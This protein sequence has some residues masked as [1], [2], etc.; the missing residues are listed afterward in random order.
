[1]KTNGSLIGRLIVG[2]ALACSLTS[3]TTQS[4]AIEGMQVSIQSSNV[5]LSWPSDPSETYVVQYRPS[6]LSTNGWQTLTNSLAAATDT[7][8]TYF[9]HS[10]SVNFGSTTGGGGTNS[11]GGGIPM[12]GGTNNVN[13]TNGLVMIA[14]T[15]FY[16]AAR[17]GVHI[18]G[19]DNFTNVMSD[20]I[21]IP[22]EVANDIGSIQDIVVLVDGT[23]YRG[24]APVVPPGINGRI[25]F[26]TSFLE[27]GDHTIQVVA[28]WLNPDATD[29]NNHGISRYSDSFTLSVSNVIYYPDWEDEIGELG[30]A[31][32]AFETTCTNST[33]QIDIY[34]VS[35]RLAK[36]LIGNTGDGFVETNWDLI[37]TNGITRATNDADGEFSAMITVGDPVTKATPHKRKPFAYPSQ[38]QWVIAYQD[39]FGDCAASNSYKGAISQFGGIAAANGGAYTI[40]PTPGHPEYGQIYPIRYPFSNNV[41]P[42]TSAQSLA[43]ENALLRILTNNA[44]RNFYYNGHGSADSIAS[45][46]ANVISDLLQKTHYYRF[47]FLDGCSTANG[48]L[49]AAFGINLSSTQP[50]SYFQAHGTR[51]RAFVGYSKDVIYSESGDFID[52]S[53]GLHYQYH[54]PDRNLYFLTNFEFYWYFNYDLTTSIYNAQNDTPD[55]RYG[56][57]DGA[58]LSVFGYDALYINQYNSQSDW[59][60]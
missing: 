60:N 39:K 24:A 9:V 25:T 7:N 47:V 46:Y 53:S 37:D 41:A 55:L 3:F 14:G 10:N 59:S 30:F 45:V 48:S 40:F 52:S 11:G 35:N 27:N 15:G 56:W 54:I 29:L 5:V 28:S 20:I 13:D 21:S 18:V 31:Y 22:F 17:L 16:Q 26:D 57:E 2:C 44:N 58:D 33:W 23:R 32:Y 34:D 6:L 8:I 36:T 12:P 4:F 38:G 49:P 19:L 1:M 50:L 51:P 43:D 42:P